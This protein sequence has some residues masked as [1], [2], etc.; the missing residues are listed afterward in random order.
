MYI[1]VKNYEHCIE[2][3]QIFEKIRKSKIVLYALALG[4]C[5]PMAAASDNTSLSGRVTDEH[6]GSPLI[7]VAVYLPELKKGAM[8]KDDGSYFI[9]QL[10]QIKTTIQ[11]SYLGHQTIIE[12]IDLG[13]VTE[14]NF[15]MHENYAMLNEVVLV[16]LTGNSLVSQT[17]APVTTISSHQLREYASSNIID[18]I[19]KEPGLS[20]ITTGNGISKPV[21]RGLSYNRVAIVKDGVRQEGQQWGDEHGVE[22][23]GNNVYS[24]QIL[25]GPASLIYGSDAMAG[26]VVMNNAPSMAEGHVEGSVTTEYQTNN[27]LQNYS[28]HLGGNHNGFVWDG[29]YSHKLAHDYRNKYD[30]RV[31]NSRFQEYAASGMMGMNKN[32]GHSHLHL[33]YYQMNPGFVEGERD[34]ESGKFIMPVNL[35]G[36]EEEA[37]YVGSKSYSR[38][39]P[40]Q[41]VYHYKAVVSENSFFIGNGQLKSIIGYQQNIRK[42]FEDVLAP[43]DCELHLKLHTVNYNVHYLAPEISGWRIASGV[44]GMWQQNVNRGEDFL[45]PDYMLFDIG[46]FATATRKVGHWNLSGGLRYDNRHVNSK[47]LEENEGIRFEAF[48]KNFGSLSGSLGTT[49]SIN[50]QSN[51]KINMSRGYRAPNI[52][53]LGSNGEHEGTLRYEIGNHNLKAESSWQFDLGFDYSSKWFSTQISLFCNRVNHYIYLRKMADG[54][55]GE[56]IIDDVPAFTYTSGNARV[57][58][59]ELMADLHPLEALHFENTFSI[60]NA[61]RTH[62][63]KGS[64]YLPLI[65][66]PRWN[67]EL[68]YDYVSH[69]KRF[70]NAFVSLMAETNFKQNH[71]LSLYGTE[72]ATPAYTLI[73]LSAGTD[74]K[75]KGRTVATLLLSLNNLTDKAYQHHLSRLKYADINQ[76]TGRRGV[77]NMGRN[78][79]MKLTIPFTMK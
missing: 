35:D 24:V 1:H 43:D 37:V 47:A 77:Y 32:W 54:A 9:D 57:Y 71:Y 58:G 17:P 52:S 65:P 14:K 30:G 72:T 26:V 73:H 70:D 63:G 49:Y 40:Y 27:G 31:F 62:A 4:M 20:Q 18:A 42:E 41:K 16:G 55:G 34:E 7:G 5:Q 44:N 19:A 76:L 11:V 33:S 36:T 56:V 79:V 53:E 23:D 25:K 28:L 60:V 10:P 13:E 68:R 21:I 2:M 78:F 48:S 64:K 66:A 59:G 51:L 29:R 38:M 61:E 8:T 39:V 50:T 46:F 45:V 3:M 75:V 69:G 22:I 12:Q 67:C 15:V 74:I 6:D